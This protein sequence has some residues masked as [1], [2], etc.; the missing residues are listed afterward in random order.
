MIL[1]V[2]F[3]NFPS[4][5]SGFASL[6]YLTTIANCDLHETFVVSSTSKDTQLD[7]LKSSIRSSLYIPPE[8]SFCVILEVYYATVATLSGPYEI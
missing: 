5:L 2:T 6:T 3:I 7:S 8:S 4:R 1:P